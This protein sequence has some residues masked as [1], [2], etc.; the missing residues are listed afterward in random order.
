ML[1]YARDASFNST[2]DKAFGRVPYRIEI[3]RQTW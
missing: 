3:V 2:C 1:R